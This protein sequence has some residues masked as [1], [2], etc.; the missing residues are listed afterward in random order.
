MLTVAIGRPG[1]IDPTNAYEPN[2]RLVVTTLCDTLLQQDPTSGDLRGSLAETFQITDT[3]SRFIVRLR[4]DLRF[5]NGQKVT[6]DDVAATLSRLASRDFAS[7][8]QDLMVLIGGFQTVSGAVETDNAEWRERLGGIRLIDARS[9]EIGLWASGR[10]SNVSLRM[11]DYLRVLTDAATSPLPRRLI[12]DDP[13]SLEHDPVCVGPYK[14]AAPWNGVARQIRLVRNPHYK[15]YNP[16]LTAGGRG[17]ADEIVFRIYDTPAARLAAWRKGEVQVAPLEPAQARQVPLA[18]LQVGTGPMV[19]FVGTPTTGRYADPRVRAALSL[20]LDRTRLARSVFGGLAEPATGFLP[21]TLGEALF[22]Q[23]A[24]DLTR[25]TLPEGAGR[26][27][28]ATNIAVTPATTDRAGAQSLLAQARVTLTGQRL[29]LR[30]NDEG[31][32]PALARAVAAQWRSALGLVV[33]LVPMPWKDYLALATSSAGLDSAFLVSWAP[34][35]PGPDQYVA[36]LFTG[37]GV[38]KDNWNHWNDP[39]YD[40]QLARYVRAAEEPE[41]LAVSYRGVERF[42][43]SQLPLIPVLFGRHATAVDTTT[44]ATARDGWLHRSTGAVLLRE[45]YRKGQP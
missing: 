45:I 3:G 4:D 44:L 18:G 24:C 41:D 42:L 20:A 2:G 43:C 26:D 15:G 13:E 30:Y 33:R 39:A 36:P 25:G 40:T 34:N 17:Y 14:L 35:Y 9:F 12:Q 23:S 8:R 1:S 7:F 28:A 22:Q 10:S 6:A 21:P 31:R 37:A 5:S 19:Q 29:D 32:N 38:G 11:A 16:A 27:L